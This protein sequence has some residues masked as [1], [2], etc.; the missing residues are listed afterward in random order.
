MHEEFCCGNIYVIPRF[1]TE[2]LGCLSSYFC[3]VLYYV[4]RV[5]AS[6]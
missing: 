2:I 1:Q 6:G 4:G 5:L 3:V